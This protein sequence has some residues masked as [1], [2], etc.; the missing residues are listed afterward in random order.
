VNILKITE[1]KENPF[2]VKIF[3]LLLGKYKGFI[4][5]IIGGGVGALTN[6]FISF[7]LTSI[8]GFHYVVSYAIAQIV[9]ITVNFLWH[10]FITFKET[11]SPIKR[12]LKFIVMSISTAMLS[13]C[14]VYIS[15]EFFLDHF[16][17]III[18]KYDL[19]YLAVIIGITFLISIL[20]YVI[21][22]VWVFEKK[23]DA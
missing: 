9:N 12:F 15:K 16:Y 3:F 21:S 13:I 2:L 19:N 4:I 1:K 6:W 7:V 22:K 11:T 14:L 5:F 10:T 23:G 8:L 17:H 18:K 20:N